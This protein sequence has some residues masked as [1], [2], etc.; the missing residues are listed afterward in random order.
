M[1]Q[2]FIPLIS[3]MVE[4]RCCSLHHHLY[5]CI[6]TRRW[7]SRLKW[8]VSVC[9]W[10]SQ[11]NKITSDIVSPRENMNYNI[12]PLK[13]IQVEINAMMYSVKGHTFRSVILSIFFVHSLTLRWLFNDTIRGFRTL[14]CR[15]FFYIY[16]NVV[17]ALNHFKIRLNVETKYPE[18]SW[19]FL[20]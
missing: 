17:Y 19:K 3:R 5:L 14:F 16:F 2:K 18:G 10:V 6:S 12:I 15:F 9:V 13:K 7:T 20:S 1:F 11:K 8:P 4:H